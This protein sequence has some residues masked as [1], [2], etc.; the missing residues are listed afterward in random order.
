MLSGSG[1][2][3]TKNPLFT[4]HMVG[5]SMHNRSGGTR[6]GG[7]FKVRPDKY[8]CTKREGLSHN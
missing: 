8:L 4:V 2:S 5:P 7:V 3:V 6:I 1:K